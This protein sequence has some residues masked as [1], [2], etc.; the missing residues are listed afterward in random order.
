MTRAL[1][2]RRASRLAAAFATSATVAAFVLL[3][4]SAAAVAGPSGGLTALSYGGYHFE[5]P[6]SWPVFDLSKQPE[7][8][9]RFDLHAVYLG[10]PAADQ[11]CPSWLL[12]ATE[13]MVIGPGPSSVRAQTV[14]NTVSHQITATAPGISVTATFD[15]DPAI[16]TGI[17]ASAGLDAPLATTADLVRP[18]PAASA[19][20]T[21]QRTTATEL[22]VSAVQQ[23]SFVHSVPVPLPVLPAGVANDVG[24]G[25]DTCAA[26]SSGVMQA[27]LA[28]SPYRAVGIYIGGADRACAQPNLTAAWVRQQAIAG[29]H[30]IPLYAGPQAAFGQ[31][32][33]PAQQGTADA[34]DAAA[35]AEALGFGLGT[36][37][38]YDMEAYSPAESVAALQFLS[39]WTSELHRLGFDSGVYSSS[40]SGISDL[41]RQYATG[42]Y[43]I[44]DVIYDAS[45]NGAAN[46]LDGNI[47]ATAWPGGLRIHQFSGNVLQTF[48]GDSMQIDQDYL[49][50]GLASAGGTTQASAAVVTAD[51][52]VSVFAM[53]A[54]HHLIEESA[55]PAGQWTRT[56]LGG[57]ISSAPTVVQVR[58]GTFDLFYRGGDDRLWELRSSGPGWLAPV[59][60]GQM[61]L[62]GAPQAVAQPDGTI[63]V[64]WHGFFGPRLWHAQYDPGLGWAGPQVL[65]GS[66]NGTP[67]PVVTPSGD[68]EVFWHGNG[69][70]NVWRVVRGGLDGTWTSPQDLGMGPLDGPP[71][72][73][74]LASGWID[75][76]WRRSQI[77]RYI[78]FAALRPGG[79]ASVPAIPGNAFGLGQPS[80]AVAAGSEWILF[81]GRLGGLRQVHLQA[82]GTWSGS[83]WVRGVAGL[84]SAPF[85]AAG[86]ASGPLDIFWVG[87]DGNLWFEQF[88]QASGWSHSSRLGSLS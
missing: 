33:A 44:P 26:P 21:R 74:P 83:T 9:V 47:P 52:W 45:W 30:F 22:S 28:S 57:T 25:F 78:Y 77:P 53:S 71:Q 2:L 56:D 23:S 75:L 29:W 87:S 86:P 54:A 59:R 63:D 55:S 40:S 50:V 14:E 7:T 62:V 69:D 15:Q 70:G 13:A 39:A 36:P 32:T 4:G 17:L 68:V 27:W 20:A 1:T 37:L 64:F 5:I 79:P 31:L 10:T 82:D 11:F 42:R 19:S 76:F 65:Y 43:A 61:G 58:P 73:V 3:A 88:T 66:L 6:A 34:D 48:G 60:L 8:C 49:D 12:G 38:Y 51:G 85:A 84:Y 81:R 46:V 67:S 35:Q 16:I 72:A 18:G 24:L 41:A 80:A